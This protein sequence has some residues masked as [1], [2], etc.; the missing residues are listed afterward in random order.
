MRKKRSG[1]TLI[2]LLIVVAIIGILA[3]IAVP[4]FMNAQIRAKLA[5]VE[6]DL[7][8]LA[9]ALTLYKVDHGNAPRDNFPNHAWAA[10]W[11]LL[12]TPVAYMNT[13]LPDV[14]QAIDIERGATHRVSGPNSPF[15][16]DY[17]TD[18]FHG[19]NGSPTHPWYLAWGD[20]EWKIGS[21]GPDRQYLSV[22]FVIPGAGWLAGNYYHPSNGLISPGDIFRA[23]N[24]YRKDRN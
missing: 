3:A 5:R 12:T 1:F 4:N 6:S 8:T 16:Y 9:T 17:G 14:F 2:E 23:E 20:S 15:T 22:D 13:I 10:S 11:A 19:Y 21:P 18:V 7:R 24:Y